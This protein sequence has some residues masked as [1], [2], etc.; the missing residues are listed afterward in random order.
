MA[1]YSADSLCFI[2]RTSYGAPAHR[3]LLKVFS[4]DAR[5]NKG[6]TGAIF[7]SH[8][9]SPPSR[10]PPSLRGCASGHSSTTTYKLREASEHTLYAHRNLLKP[11][12]EIVTAIKPI[13]KSAPRAS[14]TARQLTGHAGRGCGQ[15]AV[16]DRSKRE[17]IASSS[18]RDFRAELREV[19]ILLFACASIKKIGARDSGA[20]RLLTDGPHTVASHLHADFQRVRP[21]FFRSCY[22]V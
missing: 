9:L 12:F 15:P 11:F 6:S 22:F 2:S 7:R 14:H 10:E 20:V 8:C 21:A 3:P 19:I 16:R 4:W 1:L 5:F 13:T 18:R 17:R